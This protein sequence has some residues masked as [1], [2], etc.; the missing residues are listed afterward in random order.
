VRRGGRRRK[1]VLAVP[2]APK[3]ALDELQTEVDEIICLST[4][5]P[6]FAVGAHYAEFG[7][8]VDADVISLLKERQEAMARAESRSD[9]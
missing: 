1:I 7:Q 5:S 6:F 3:D 8:L 2:V 4:P 9:G